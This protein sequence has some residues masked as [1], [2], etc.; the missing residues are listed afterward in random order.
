[1]TMAGVQSDFRC[2]F[3]GKHNDEV[4]RLI[5]GPQGAFI[6]NEC[7]AKASDILAKEEAEQAPTQ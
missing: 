6:C 1:M 5:A 4:R 7:V 2:R 3:C